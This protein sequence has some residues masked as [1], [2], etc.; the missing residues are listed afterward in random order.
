VHFIDQ[1]IVIVKAGKGGN[2]IVSF[3][4]EKF[5]PAGGPSGGNGGKGGSVIFEA[6]NNLQTLLDFNFN[7]E[8]VAKDGS[9]GGPNRRSG[10]S[11]EDKIVKVPCGT[12]IRDLNTGI[13]LG[14]LVQN[15]DKIVVARGGRGGLGNAHFLS[16][17]NRAPEFCIDG[18][19]GEIW[20]IKLELKLIA[21]VGI[22]GLPNAGKSTLI[23]VLSSASPKIANYPFTTL[24]PNL[25][26][27]RKPDGNGCLFADIP[28][29]ISGAAEG[30][31]LG[32]DFL[33]HIERTK[34]LIHLIDVAAE[35]PLFDYEVIE[36]EL[37]KYGNGLISKERLIVLTKIELVEE[38]YLKTI[39]KK[40]ENVSKKKVFVIS[41]SL[42][43]G[44]SPLLSE[45]WSK[46]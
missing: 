1:A 27:V 10:A 12:E 9:K 11:G 43:K 25:G 38:D 20:E 45:V 37:N 3:R 26:V 32:H 14:D 41:S 15:K 35:K 6:D 5:V 17:Q 36:D 2:G 19:E 30:I 46:V 7:R 31:G 29:L 16:N 23:S 39:T 28:G 4:R 13:I 8:I 44:L 40:L 33:R 24:V 18:R 42:R 34:I 22:I 21:E